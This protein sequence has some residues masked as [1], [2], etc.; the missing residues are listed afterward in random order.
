L[1]AAWALGLNYYFA[2]NAQAKA[3]YNFN[4]G[5]RGEDSDD[6]RFQLQFAYGF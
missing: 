3:A 1:V 6:D 5:M 4:D 2:P